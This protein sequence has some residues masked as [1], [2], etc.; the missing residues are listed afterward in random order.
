MGKG[1]GD[2]LESALTKI[3]VTSER[4]EN[5]LGTP[6]NCEERKQKLNQLGNWARRVI[7][8]RTKDADKYLNNIMEE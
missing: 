8:G 3:G 6:C 7:S 1:L 4:V 2:V 5:W